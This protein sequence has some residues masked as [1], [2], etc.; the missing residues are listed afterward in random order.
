M[1]R[2][3]TPTDN[4]MI[5]SLNG[6]IKEDMRIDF[7]SKSVEGIPSFIEGMFMTLITKD[8]LTNSMTKPLFNIILNKGLSNWWF[9]LSTFT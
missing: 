2:A 3:G 5:E 7:D 4:P 8:Y 1:S 6:W 9:L